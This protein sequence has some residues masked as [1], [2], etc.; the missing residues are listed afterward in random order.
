VGG[1]QPIR[2]VIANGGLPVIAAVGAK[3][4]RGDQQM[5]Q[6][7][8]HSQVLLQDVV[9]GWQRLTDNSSGHVAIVDG[10]R[11]EQPYV[12]LVTHLVEM[13]AAG[14]QEADFDTLAAVSGASALYG[15]Q[16][17]DFTPKY[18]HLMVGPDERIAEATG[19]GYEWVGWE[20]A[21][22]CWRVLKQTLD[23]GRPAKGWDW[24]N[25]LFAGYQDA[26]RPEGRQVFMM[27][28]GPDTFCQW[29]TWAQFLEWAERV[30][31]WGQKS[32]GRH[33][34]RVAA[35]PEQEVAQRV[36]R[37]LVA[38]AEAPPAHVGERLGEATLGL[39][40][41]ERYAAD[42]ADVETYDT[43]TAC[44][45]INPQ[46][47]LRR[48]T[49]VYLERVAG[50]FPAAAGAKLRASAE[51]Y[52]AAFSAWQG[53]YDLLGHGAPKDAGKDPER[54]EAGAELARDWSAHE[55]A[56]V[57]ELREALGRFASA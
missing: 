3:D 53:F 45:D 2:A 15:Y 28:D 17:R 36:I 19:F 51:E 56:A 44:H 50:L 6:Q 38:W 42:C 23:S 57:G 43:W 5:A 35:L 32:L 55:S 46:W 4:A 25:C 16:P 13:W 12:Y 14:W 37:D 34:K 26:E 39:A 22:E 49:A 1:G 24:E 40:G 54:R 48:S 31:N 30:S 33:T 10:V 52:H 27:A 7:E 20:G 41:I 18:A 21:E 9:D 11:Y 8:A 29:R 47:T